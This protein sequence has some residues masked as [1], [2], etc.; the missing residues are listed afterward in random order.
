MARLTRTQKYAELRNQLEQSPEVEVKSKDLSKYEDRMN[1]L[2]IDTTSLKP[3]EEAPVTRET[4]PLEEAPLKEEKPEVKEEPKKEEKKEKPIK[5]E[6]KEEDQTPEESFEELETFDDF[7][8]FDFEEKEEPKNT[9]EPVELDAD[10]EVKIDDNYLN[11]ALSEVNAYNKAQGLLTADDV[12]DA[13][14]QEIRS[15]QNQDTKDEEITN[16]VTPEIKKILSELD[17]NKEEAEDF[18]KVE[19]EPKVEAQ[20]EEVVNKEPKE[21]ELSSEVTDLLKTYLKED[22]ETSA[23]IT[24]TLVATDIK[25]LEGDLETTKQALKAE[26]DKT[27]MNETLPINIENNKKVKK[28]EELDIEP[29]PNKILNFILTVLIIVLI[30]ILAF[31]GYLILTARGII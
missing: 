11:E 12:S 14:V 7:E 26:G 22:E 29:R 23:D 8:P 1:D 10:E 6:I 13:I 27:L 4:L 28:E 21:E 18:K 25:T 17:T 19:E 24:K 9:D 30:A 15:S 31:I 16:T 2:H 5:E 3:K 20:K